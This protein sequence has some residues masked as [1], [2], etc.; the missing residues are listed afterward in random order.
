MH[1]LKPINIFTIS[2][3]LMLY[4]FS[5]IYKPINNYNVCLMYASSRTYKHIYNSSVWCCMCLQGHTR[6]QYT[7]HAF[8]LVLC[9]DCV[10]EN[11]YT[12]IYKWCRLSINAG[13][14][15]VLHARICQQALGLWSCIWMK[16][17]KAS[18]I[19]CS[20]CV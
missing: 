9:I 16:T 14:C 4:V 11:Q 19:L 17:N 8:V 15:V 18:F 1:P 3:C 5:K 7:L 13:I 12:S 10:F 20:V 2:M 6:D